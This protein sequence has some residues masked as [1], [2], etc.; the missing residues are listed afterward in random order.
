MRQER[1]AVN[2]GSAIPSAGDRR[3]GPV[4]EAPVAEQLFGHDFVEGAVVH[5][6]I[7]RAEAEAL[8]EGLDPNL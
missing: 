3:V 8:D 4:Q 1:C 5:A 6:A 7:V 2:A